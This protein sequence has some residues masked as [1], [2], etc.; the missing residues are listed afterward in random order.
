MR[1]CRS[2]HSSIELLLSQ[3]LCL[4]STESS[5]L[6]GVLRALLVNQGYFLSFGATFMLNEPGDGGMLLVSVKRLQ[7]YANGSFEYGRTHAFY[8]TPF[9]ATQMVKA[10][11]RGVEGFLLIQTVYAE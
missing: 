6:L 8:R 1:V 5:Q 3:H 11:T 7:H 9:D 10:F 2:A 4:L